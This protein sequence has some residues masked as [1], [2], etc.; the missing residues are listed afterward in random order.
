MFCPRCDSEMSQSEFG[1]VHVDF[2]Q[3]GC[4]GLWFDWGELGRVDEPD[5]GV[6]DALE[7]ALARPLAADRP[8]PLRCSRCAIPMQEHRYKAVPRVLIDECY[9][10][11]G[12]FL[13]PGELRLIRD[14]LRERRRKER[15][16]EQLLAN[17]V[18]YRRHQIEAEAERDRARSLETLSR[19]LTQKMLWF[20]W[21]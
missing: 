17:D 9:A 13:D 10:C 20:P 5:E 1:V 19:V 3:R 12:F 16:V 6:G 2:C 7:A 8:R 14:D 4:G 18:V 11:R 15:A 21:W